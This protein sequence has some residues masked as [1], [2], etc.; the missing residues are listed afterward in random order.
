MPT[1]IFTP[2]MFTADDARRWGPWRLD[3]SSYEL[4]L[5]TRD[6]R[7]AVPLLGCTSSSAVLDWLM[8][9]VSSGW[10]DVPHAAS[11]LLVAFDDLLAPRQTLCNNARTGE[12]GTTLTDRAVAARIDLLVAG[13]DRSKLIDPR[14][15]RLT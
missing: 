11:G 6:E 3:P 12:A 9:C 7:Y 2:F 10:V 4:V 15:S 14:A 13:L 5:R 1:E 8:H